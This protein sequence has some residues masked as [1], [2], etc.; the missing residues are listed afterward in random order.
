MQQ[1]SGT[2]TIRA[3]T[4]KLNAFN[5]TLQD[6][7]DG[8]KPGAAG[9]QADPACAQQ[10]AQHGREPPQQ[11][12]AFNVYAEEQAILNQNQAAGAADHL[13]GSWPRRETR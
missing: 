5:E 11:I 9:Y 3:T 12:T 1:S 10:L 8:T 6:L 4:D 7:L 13:L 2:L